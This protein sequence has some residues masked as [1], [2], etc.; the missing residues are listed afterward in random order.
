MSSFQPNIYRTLQCQKVCN[1]A[2]ND[3]QKVS[4]L[5]ESKMSASCIQLMWKLLFAFYTN[6]FAL[7]CC[8][9]NFC[10]PT[11]NTNVVFTSMI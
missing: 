6:N 1:I 11:E 4:I 2:H 7:F 3:A 10:T 8:K 9:W 5:S